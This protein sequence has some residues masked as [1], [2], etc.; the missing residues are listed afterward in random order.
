MPKILIIYQSRTGNTTAMAEAVEEGVRK[1]LGKESK[2]RAWMT[3]WSLKGWS[4]KLL[5]KVNDI[6]RKNPISMT[7]F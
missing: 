5:R 7:L 2:T 1:S 3:F 6:S 4:D